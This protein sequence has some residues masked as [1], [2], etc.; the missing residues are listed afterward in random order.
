MPASRS[1][2]TRPALR[3]GATPTGAP[4]SDIL[5]EQVAFDGQGLGT[6]GRH[7][8]LAIGPDGRLYATTISGDLKRWD[9][10]PDGT[11]ANFQLIT[12]LRDAEGAS[13]MAIGLVFDPASTADSLVAWVSHS[14]YGFSGQ[15]DWGGKIARLSGPDLGTVKNYVVNLPRSIRDH[16]TN[17]MA[18]GPDGALYVLQGSNSAM[19]APDDAWG[20]RPERKLSAALLRVDVGALEADGLLPLDVKTEEGGTYDPYAAAAPVKVY[21]SGLRNAYDLV[22][23]SNGHLYVPTNGSAANGNA[24]ASVDGAVRPDGTPYNGPTVAAIDSVE[25]QDDF[26]FR[27]P[28]PAADGT[29]GYHYYGHPNPSRGEFVLNGGNPTT[30][31][32]PSQVDRYPVGVAPD[33]A[34]AGAAYNFGRSVSPNG[35]IEYQGGA[36]EGALRGKL[37]VVRYSGGDDI[38]ALA[39]NDTDGDIAPSGDFELVVEGV[40]V[41]NDPLELTEDLATGNLYL[42]EY[43]GVGRISLLRPVDGTVN[44]PPV[45]SFTASPA[46]PLAVALD[47]SAS[48]DPDGSVTGWRWEFGDGSPVDSTSGPTVSHTYGAAGTYAVTLTVTDGGGATGST[49][50]DVTVS[51][52]AVGPYLES[53]GLVVF[54]AE[55]AERTAR[56][57]HAWD[58]AANLAGAVGGAVAATPNTGANV[59]TDVPNSSPEL[60]WPVR[61]T[62]AG[63]YY[64]WGR[65][66]AA[67]NDD[68]SFHAGLDGA[69]VSTASRVTAGGATGG[70]WTWARK[71]MAGASATLSVGAGDHTVNVWMREDGLEFDRALLTTDPSYVPVGTGPPESLRDGDE[72]PPPV[73]ELTWSQVAPQPYANTEAQAEAVGGKLYVFGGFDILKKQGACN[74]FTPTARAYVY[75]PAA[76]TWSPIKNLPFPNGG[77]VTH[78]GITTD[79]ADIFLASG[80]ISN[81][82]GTGQVFGTRQVW[83]YNVA[84]NTYTRLP[85]LPIERAAGQLQ[86]VGGKLHY[87][88]GTNKARTVDVAD[89]Y[90]LDYEAFAA[91][92]SPTWASAAPFPNPRHHMGSAVYE[93]RIYAVGGQHHHDGNAVPQ[94]SVHSY[95]PASGTWSEHAPMPT[96]LSHIAVTLHEGQIVVLG[97]EAAP[98]SDRVAD[99]TAYDPQTDTWAQL[100]PLPQVRKSGVGV[101]IGGALYY[102]TGANSNGPTAVTYRGA[103]EGGTVNRPPVA[104]FTASPAGPLAVAL[105]GS[106]SSDPD[107]SVT[108]WRWEFGDGSPVDSTS[109]PTVS[110][111]YGAAGTYAVTLTVTDGGGATGS[112]TR[113]VAVTDGATAPIA[114]AGSAAVAQSGPSAWTAVTFGHTFTDPVVVAGPPSYAGTDPAAV[115]VRAVTAAGFEVQVDEWDYLDGKH[116]SEAVAWLAAEAGSHQLADGRRFEAG[117]VTADGAWKAVTF[118]SPFSSAPVVLVT[119]SAAAV[120]AGA[121]TARLR[122]VTATGFEVLLQAQES[123]TTPPTGEEVSWVAVAAGP[124]GT[125]ASGSAGV[126]YGVGRTTSTVTDQPSSTAFGSPFASAPV[127]V[128]AMQ[129]FAGADPAALRRTAVS[130][131]AFT[132]FVEEEKSADSEVRHGGEAVG[133]LAAE[134]GVLSGSSQGS[135][136]ALAAVAPLLMTGPPP[137][138]EAVIE[139]IWPN[140]SRGAAQVRYGVPE[141]GTVVVEVFDTVGRRVAV[142]AEGSQSEGWHE[143]E[144]GRLGLPA[145]VYLVR[146][147]TGAAAVVRSFTIV[148]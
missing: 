126:T 88:G 123:I 22:W 112:T 48:S 17:G 118:G 148:R 93:G 65:V 26:L 107:G 31:E 87:F 75:D 23:H 90:V 131:S 20:N 27:V 51:D 81:A 40:P 21:A 25:T 137:P 138:D 33:V 98:P 92:G 13:R 19:G 120:G 41:F 64:V 117:R 108:G 5:F 10:N 142:L 111:T 46:G 55:S 103:S 101:S 136:E 47:G 35:V 145:G 86:Y 3:R 8:S 30:L 121:V 109:G 125:S 134:R 53:D 80:Y 115:R 102:S 95:D 28:A 97:G 78:A 104:S 15:P 71:T 59:N 106:A 84:G 147:Q 38:V 60:R 34:W 130:A 77:G 66:R 139:G 128:A 122:N 140:P 132:V 11:L 70:G 91:G 94:A 74:C 73:A 1:C 57:G 89:H 67:T 119:P 127:V 85:D 52:E 69:A 54:E 61:F 2:R 124:A 36:F 146:L 16:V 133:W 141:A 99:V 32:D 24:P 116:A 100:T 9:I 68:D 105:D 96:A 29:W 76:D 144:V 113:D 129:T 43:G 110:H 135:P 7:S 12:S 18:F 56:G 50:R 4:T 39:P 14:K 143:A 72:P 58:T 82:D 62:T 6:E 79:G 49:T 37:L 83:R 63:T 44:R 45:A 114:E 42:S